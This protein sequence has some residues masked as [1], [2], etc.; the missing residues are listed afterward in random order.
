MGPGSGT[1]C[2]AHLLVVRRDGRVTR[3]PMKDQLRGGALRCG[4]Y[5]HPTA[6][7]WP[8]GPHRTWMRARA[9]AK[10]S[11]WYTMTLHS[12]GRLLD[13]MPGGAA[14]LTTCSRTLWHCACSGLSTTAIVCAWRA[15]PDA[16]V[17]FAPGLWPAG[18]ALLNHSHSRK[19]PHAGAALSAPGQELCVLTGSD[20][21]AVGAATAQCMTT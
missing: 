2:H 20:N 21:T 7:C 18:F 8:D 15:T 3:A 14:F 5:R 13:A 9:P 10:V 19:R 1:R 16:Y 12:S 17:R 4:P 6:R 11:R